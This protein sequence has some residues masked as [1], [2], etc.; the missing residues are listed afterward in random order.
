MA[1]GKALDGKPDAGNPHVRFDEG[2]VASC[3]A[4][5]S[6]RRV[7]CRR[8]PEGRASVC[9]ATPRR[10]SLLYRRNNVSRILAAAFAVA[11]VACLPIAVFAAEWFVSPSGN[12]SAAGTEAAPFRTL[13]N[14]V[15]RASA[16]DIVT[17]LPGDHVEGFAT[18][19]VSGNSSKSRVVIDKKLTIR[20]K[21]GRASRDTT[22]IVGAWDTTEYA[23][24]PWGF[25][26]NAVRCVW[27]AESGSGT[28][29]EGITFANGS[30]PVWNVQGNDIGGGGGVLVYQDSTTATI[31]DCAVVNCQGFNGGGICSTYQSA[32]RV[33]VV[34]TLFKRCRGSKF[35]QALRGGAAYNCVFDDNGYTCFKDGTSKVDGSC[36]RGGAF[37]YAYAAINCT[38]VNNKSW[39]VGGDSIFSGG[40]YNC[41][42]QKNGEPSGICTEKV[43][44][45]KAGN[46]LG[47][48]YLYNKFEVISPFDGDYRL[49]S[50]ADARNAGD[51]TKVASIPE[52][53][54]GTDYYGNPLPSSGSIHAGAVQSALTGAASGVYIAK[55]TGDEEGTWFVGGEETPLV[56][57][58]WR[59]AEGWPA[60]FQMKF[61]PVEGRALV[62]YAQ[63]ASPVWPLRDDSV[64]ITA[65][66]NQVQGVSP[67]TTA[68]IFYADPVNGSDEAGDGSES[69]PYK[70][71]NKAVKKTTVSFVVRAL[72]GD[73]CS[74]T[75]EYAGEKNRV[76][77]PDTLAGDL[78]VVA[79]GGPENT[80]IT[81]ASDPS[82]ASNGTGANAVR[83]IA[84]ASTNAHYAA[85]QGFTLRDGR[86]GPNA[87]VPSQGAAIYNIDSDYN[88]F[89]TA[90]LL[91]CVVTNCSGNRGATVSGGSAYR[92]RFYDCKTFNSNGQCL[93]RY[94]SIVSSLFVGCGG[95]SQ[96]FGNTAKGYNCTIYGSVGDMPQSIY[97]NNG[98]KGYLYNCVSGRPSGT[99]I[100]QE[101]T[102]DQLVNTLYCRM[103]ASNPNTFTTAV[104]E[105]PLK[106]MDA[107]AGD[108]R[109]A[110]DS[111]GLYLASA[112]YLQSCMDIEGNPY[113]F[114]T[115]T[116]RYQAG[117][118]ATR[119]GVSLYVDAVNGD[120]ANDGS[121][122]ADAF[123]TL[124]AA[125]AA[126]DYGDTVLALPGTYDSGTM[127][128]TLA[129]SG[130]DVEPALRSRVV[131]K[132]GVTLASRDGAAATIIQGA[133]S[134]DA[135]ATSGCGEG[136]VR[137]A[138]LCKNAVLRG[139]TVTGGHT[140]YGSTSSMTVN[141]YG[142][143]VGGYYGASATDE[144]FSGLVEDCVITGNVA[145]RGGGAL[146]GTYRNCLFTDNALAMDKPGWAVA[147]S[148][149]EGCFFSG[150]G[151]SG[152]HSAIYGCDVVNCTVLGGQAGNTGVICNESGYQNRRAVLNTIVTTGKIKANVCTNCLFGSGVS[153]IFDSPRAFGN[154]VG[155]ALL[156]GNGVPLA[157]SPA[158][159]AG[160]NALASDELLAGRDPAGTRR[161]LNG[162]VDIGAYEYDWGV[163]W[164]RAIGGRRLVIDDMP[165]DATLSGG[166][167]LVFGGAE[168]PVSMTWNKGV[169]LASYTFN[170]EV[171]GSGTLTVTANGA[172]VATLTAADG[173]QRLSFNSSLDDNALCFAYDGV[174]TDG[175]RLSAFNHQTPFMLFVR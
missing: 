36:W 41:L 49:T 58:T 83:C 19:T 3:T 98:T 136:A 160:D 162:T 17:L 46:V 141:D 28:R 10:G 138:F 118:Y 106:L 169:S 50:N 4:E 6:L 165:S 66:R 12:D 110:T 127:L 33:K 48:A 57:G 87:T 101:P 146:F 126:A 31:V 144:E 51:A 112:D 62:R 161:V 139:F 67:V 128:Q 2:E 120:D 20:S 74:A 92:C 117:C 89:D 148:R 37:S 18:T 114:D 54:R 38:F 152:N 71:L 115:G 8:Q 164:G 135:G 145:C 124:A 63:G 94:C 40:V 109:L 119:V 60:A 140:L 34:R 96:L 7:H 93:L 64:W 11:L 125:M 151:A 100:G 132:N 81:G 174:E 76:V 30:V 170:A 142:G 68:N 88:N 90:L 80:F 150:N 85:F 77:V 39:G 153:N 52:E 157:G 23:D 27:I 99:D 175:V 78:R 35:G 168:V 69:N 105:E 47:N 149:L 172:E 5:A 143:G 133:A 95:K 123:Q 42:F 137:G 79:V 32:G 122:E 61:V 73:Y 155:A 91:D 43:T 44:G 97:N 21:N 9:A 16:N 104:K 72:P 22:R 25:G 131:V 154:I 103:A 167:E 130:G 29:L 116:G 134:T 26:P 45:P 147:R 70:T 173:A 158:I 75:E 82:G 107:A 84:V 171:T 14:A 53:F 13:T 113:L 163:P 108:Y 121:S 166:N 65:K 102:D 86:T 55:W 15:A 129:Q 56:N 1:T 156:D 111:A 24:L 159:D 59:G